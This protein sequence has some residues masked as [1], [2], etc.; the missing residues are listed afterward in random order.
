MRKSNPLIAVTMLGSTVLIGLNAATARPISLSDCS[1]TYNA[2]MQKC[3]GLDA[4]MPPPIPRS[5]FG[6]CKDRKSTRLN[7]SH[8]QKS[9]MPSSA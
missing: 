8:I 1:R 6:P 5:W 7:S 9:R 2:C 3:G 4:P